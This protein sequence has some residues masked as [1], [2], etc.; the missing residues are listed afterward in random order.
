VG[1]LEQYKDVIASLRVAATPASKAS[2][3]LRIGKLMT[4][5]PATRTALNTY[6]GAAGPAKQKEYIDDRK[7]QIDANLASWTTGAGAALDKIKAAPGV[8][9]ADQWDAT[10][11]MKFWP[12]IQPE[13]L[14]TAA[15]IDTVT[16]GVIKVFDAGSVWD[17][18]DPAFQAGWTTHGGG[19]AGWLE[20]CKAAG[21]LVFAPAGKEALPPFLG[22]SVA[23]AFKQTVRGFVGMG[24]DAAVPTSF[25]HA[26]QHFA[27]NAGWYPSGVMFL[28]HCTKD[29]LKGL[30][31]ALP[32]GKPSIFY[33]LVFDENTY[34]PNDRTFG[35]LADPADPTKPGPARELQT[36]G[37]PQSEFLGSGRVL[38]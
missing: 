5:I 30:V 37:L 27:L 26:I 28:G 35:H 17:A 23:D 25:A 22:K 13:E 12:A 19:K 31:G 36:T 1:T 3:A 10:G 20:A 32:I 21:K 11:P 34:E 14:T 7:A 29:Y 38:S 4:A 24:T 9:V 2:V 18:M 8:N 33:L 15:V 16:Q 6:Y